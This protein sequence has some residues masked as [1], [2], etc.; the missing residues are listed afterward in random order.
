MS[1]PI[2]SEAQQRRQLLPRRPSDRVVMW[3]AVAGLAAAVALRVDPI[4]G[5]APAAVA[6]IF[7]KVNGHLQAWRGGGVERAFVMESTA[8]S[9]Y[10]LVAVLVVVTVV[11][12]AG[13]VDRVD[14]GL[15]AVSSL[16]IDT[17][18]R[19]WRESRFT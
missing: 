7:Q 19:S 5:L 3:L 14:V 8:L 12:A 10:V 18:V 4:I 13:V 1:D 2:P 17:T 6:A 15:L 9:F 11:Q 16:F